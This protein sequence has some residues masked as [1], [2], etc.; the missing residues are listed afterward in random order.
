LDATSVCAEG[1]AFEALHVWYRSAEFTPKRLIS[2]R[3]S[4]DEGKAVWQIRQ[5]RA[6]F[7]AGLARA[8]FET[9]QLLGLDIMSPSELLS[10]LELI[11]RA[12]CLKVI[13]SARRVDWR[14]DIEVY[15]LG[16]TPVRQLMDTHKDQP[17]CLPVHLSAL[18]HLDIDFR[19]FSAAQWA[20]F[21]ERLHIDSVECL[22]IHGE[23][24]IS[25][26]K[27]FLLR[28]PSISFLEIRPRPTIFERRTPPLQALRGKLQLQQLRQLRGSLY[29]IL[30]LLQSLTHAPPSLCQLDIFAEDLPYN[31]FMHKVKQCL[32]LCKGPVC[33]SLDYGIYGHALRTF[34]PDPTSSAIRKLR[35]KMQLAPVL[36]LEITFNDLSDE[37]VMV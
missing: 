8:Q 17:Q 28:H 7:S 35:S 2:C 16:P 23:S 14:R 12:G 1:S 32:A 10:L 19:F 25:T 37:L 13:I 30:S 4:N 22:H 15:S 18:E 34:N 27:N 9:V 11:D 5:L 26:L 31:T 29:H 3:F 21:L 33:L 20:A 24:S 6:F 36:K